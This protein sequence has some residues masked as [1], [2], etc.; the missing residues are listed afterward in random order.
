MAEYESTECNSK[1]NYSQFSKAPIEA[2]GKHF[3]AEKASQIRKDLWYKYS[4]PP[5]ERRHAVFPNKGRQIDAVPNAFLKCVLLP[6]HQEAQSILLAPPLNRGGFLV[7]WNKRTQ[8]RATIGLSGRVKYHAALMGL[9]IPNSHSGHCLPAMASPNLTTVQCGSQPTRGG[10]G[11]L[12]QSTVPT[13]SSLWVIPTQTP[14]MWVKEPP[15]DSSPQILETPS[16]EAPDL[17]Q[18]TPAIPATPYLNSWP[19]EFMN[20]IQ[21][22]LSYGGKY[23]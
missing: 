19:I 23:G 1:T 10:H 6:S 8:C 22:L 11:V 14:D 16:A 5:P 7:A 12:Y 2:V 13:E 4:V 9:V 17:T 20:V 21:L 15:D 3:Q 18:Q